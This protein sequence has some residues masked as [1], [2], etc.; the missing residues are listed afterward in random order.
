[1]AV[2][3]EQEPQDY[4]TSDNPVTWVFSSDQTAQSNFYFLVDVQVGLTS[5]TTVEEHRVYPE[6][7]DNAH[8]DG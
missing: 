5:Y 4:T 3:I 6:S 1:M 8:F 7:N 2:I